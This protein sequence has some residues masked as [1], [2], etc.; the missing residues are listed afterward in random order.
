MLKK[1]G[2]LEKWGKSAKNPLNCIYL[3]PHRT[4]DVLDEW[5]MAERMPARERNADA[6]DTRAL[7][8]PADERTTW[9]HAASAQ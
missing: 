5:P 3:Q 6:G 4:N 1:S 8:A 2:I 7:P 9:Q